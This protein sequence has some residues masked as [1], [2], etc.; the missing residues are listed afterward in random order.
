MIAL[1]LLQVIKR[2]T[3]VI[4]VGGGTVAEIEKKVNCVKNL[5]IGK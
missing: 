4:C 1:S 5:L 3:V 2:I